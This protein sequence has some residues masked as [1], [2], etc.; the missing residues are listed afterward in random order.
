MRFQFETNEVLV[1]SLKSIAKISNIKI[2][3]LLSLF[4][5][6][7]LDKAYHNGVLV[8]DTAF[9]SIFHVKVI[10][11]LRLKVTLSG[12]MSPKDSVSLPGRRQQRRVRTLLCNPD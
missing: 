11:I 12:L 6:V 2:T 4:S 1:T 7:A 9:V 3:R 5:K 10:L 8:T